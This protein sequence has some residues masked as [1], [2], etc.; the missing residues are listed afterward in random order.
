[1]RGRVSKQEL[2]RRIEALEARLNQPTPAPLEGQ[3][4]IP[5]DGDAE[6]DRLPATPPTR[7]PHRQ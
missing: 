2:L 7:P 3:Q 1:M 6:E 4:V 5:L